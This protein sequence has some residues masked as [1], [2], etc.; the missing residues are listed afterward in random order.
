MEGLKHASKMLCEL[1]TS[2]LSPKAYYELCKLGWMAGTF[3]KKRKKK[4]KR[5]RAGRG[6][7]SV[8]T[9][10]RVGAAALCLCFLSFFRRDV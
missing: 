8:P 2:V 5:E 10:D 6:R 4:R 3:Q 9:V 1:R 7:A